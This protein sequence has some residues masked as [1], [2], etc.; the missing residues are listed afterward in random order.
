MIIKGEERETLRRVSDCSIHSQNV[1]VEVP[2]GFFLRGRCEGP[3]FWRTALRK[4]FTLIA[5]VCA[6]SCA[7]RAHSFV[8]GRLR[9][10]AACDHTVPCCGRSVCSARCRAADAQFALLC[11]VL[12]AVGDAESEPHSAHSADGV[13]GKEAMASAAHDFRA[14]MAVK[15]CLM[16]RQLPPQ[17]LHRYLTLPCWQMLPPPQSLH[18]LFSLPCWQILLPPQ[19]LHLFLTLPCWQTPLLDKAATGTAA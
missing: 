18:L 5:R 4:R 14:Q 11:N 8:V 1:A 3:V 12:W 10:A 13:C 9:A 17:S 16:T 15:A 7:R 19:S 2:N 6:H